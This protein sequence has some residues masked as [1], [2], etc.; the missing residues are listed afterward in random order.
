MTK[1]ESL[2]KEETAF[3][4]ELDMTVFHKDIYWGR[5]PMKI[6][7]IRKTEL[8]LEGDYSGGTHAV[9][10]KGW[11]PL[12]GTFRLRKVCEQKDEKGSCPHHNL[13]CG[14]PDCEPYLTIHPE[15]IN[16]NPSTNG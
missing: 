8:E 12:K 10:Q 4:P 5:E 1:N 6:V 15:S 9:C 11:M 16:K 13:H 2:T 3:K 14:Y 7:G